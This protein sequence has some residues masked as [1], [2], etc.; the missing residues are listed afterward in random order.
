MAHDHTSLGDDFF[1]RA[2]AAFSEP[3]LLELGMMIG[4]YLGFGRWLRALDLERPDCPIEP[5]TRG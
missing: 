4:Q 3:E 5:P 1:T 2:R